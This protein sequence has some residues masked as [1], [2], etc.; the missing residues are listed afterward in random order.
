MKNCLFILGLILVQYSFHS[1]SSAVI[2]NPENAILRE[3]ENVPDLFLPEEGVELDTK[4]CKSPMIDPRDN[5]KIIMVS[6]KNSM[7]N[8]EVP[9]GKYGVGK[10][11]LLRLDCTNGK[12]LGIVKK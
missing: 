4:S 7:G 6:S 8:Y 2:T 5:S 9:V 3:A 10:G 1:C 11:E 12:V